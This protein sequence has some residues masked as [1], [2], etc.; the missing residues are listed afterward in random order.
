MWWHQH[1]NSGKTPARYLALRWDSRKH[2]FPLSQTEDM[3]KDSREGGN[4]IEYEAEDPEIRRMFEEEL[5]RAGA[6][7]RMDEYF[8][9]P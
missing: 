1:F 7:S 2:Y 4:Q 8:K 6:Q 3:M 9:N 5:S